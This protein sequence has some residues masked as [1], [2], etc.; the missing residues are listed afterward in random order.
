MLSRKQHTPSLFN[1][2]G[3]PE[4]IS[5]EV[6]RQVLIALV[7]NY[8]NCE[9]KATDADANTKRAVDL[10]FNKIQHFLIKDNQSAEMVGIFP[11]DENVNL[12]PQ[13]MTDRLAALLLPHYKITDVEE[14]I[15]KNNRH[16]EN[17]TSA[18][19]AIREIRQNQDAL[20]RNKHLAKLAAPTKELVF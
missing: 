15:T 11:L 8:L 5:V 4:I 1:P 13:I 9:R 20:I 10:A 6:N 7:N 16:I 14:E 12:I 18:G 19:T 2:P 17:N 3:G